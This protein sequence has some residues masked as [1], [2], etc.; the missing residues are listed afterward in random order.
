MHEYLMR[1]WE[2]EPIDNYNKLQEDY[3]SGIEERNERYLEHEV[4]NNYDY[5]RNHVFNCIEA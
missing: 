4:D 1:C 2:L 5:L 3:E